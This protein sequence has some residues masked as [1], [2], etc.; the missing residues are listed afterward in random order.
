MSLHLFSH[1][2]HSA[3]LSKRSCVENC[4]FNSPLLLFS[5]WH[6]MAKSCV[7]LGGDGEEVW[8]HPA[9]LLDDPVP[10]IAGCQATVSA[11][12]GT[13]QNFLD[14]R[15]HLASR[16]FSYYS[17]SMLKEAGVEKTLINL[18]CKLSAEHYLPILAH[19][20]VTTEALHHMTSSDLKKVCLHY[21]H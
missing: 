19:H 11:H 14:T 8:C 17:V 1:F 18:L 7:L 5:F 10:E 20:R 13:L 16:L 4:S 21:T 12:A 2:T 3:A 6:Q 15:N 9:E